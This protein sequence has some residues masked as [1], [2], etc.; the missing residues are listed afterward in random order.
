MSREIRFHQ[1]T[2]SGWTKLTVE[3][4]GEIVGWTYRKKG[5]RTSDVYYLPYGAVQAEKASPEP[6]PNK[7][8]R[9]WLTEVAI[10]RGGEL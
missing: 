9:E 8:A 4:G 3:V 2:A 6:I 5:A 10:R 1:T 7:D